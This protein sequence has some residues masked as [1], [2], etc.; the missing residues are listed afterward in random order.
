MWPCHC[1]TY[2]P[3]AG[4]QELLVPNG[5]NKHALGS[6]PRDIFCLQDFTLL[7]NL[8]VSRWLYHTTVLVTSTNC[9]NCQQIKELTDDEVTLGTKLSPAI[10]PGFE[11]LFFETQLFLDVPLI[12]RGIYVVLGIPMNS[13]VSTFDIQHATPSY[14]PS[15]NEKTAS[16][17]TFTNPFVAIPT[18]NTEFAELGA[19]TLQQC[20]WNNRVKL[21]PKGYSTTTHKT[22]LC[23]GSLFYNYKSPA[24][25]NCQVV[26]LLLRDAP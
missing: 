20:S 9:Q 23:L 19:H 22:L 26:L 6:I 4:N 13:K 1:R 17:Y 15:N 12:P 21:C 8:F 3:F 7:D 14:Q 25:R 16:L 18:D 24:L 5:D 11:A 2:A 10:H